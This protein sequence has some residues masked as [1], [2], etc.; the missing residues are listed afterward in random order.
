MDSSEQHDRNALMGVCATLVSVREALGAGDAS[1]ARERLAK[2]IGILAGRMQVWPYDPIPSRTAVR[3]AIE[4]AMEGLREAM[5]ALKAGKAQVARQA[6]DGV[7]ATVLQACSMDWWQGLS[8][9]DQR[10]WAQHADSEQPRHAYACYLTHEHDRLLR[11]LWR[12][13]AVGKELN[14]LADA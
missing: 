1:D 5:G 14:R 9:E 7:A 4:Q 13:E 6:M 2:R 3:Y 12:I 10:Q 11:A 8:E